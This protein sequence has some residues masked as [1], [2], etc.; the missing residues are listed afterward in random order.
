MGVELDA[1]TR[2]GGSPGKK[3]GDRRKRGWKGVFFRK[4]ILTNSLLQISWEEYVKDSYPDQD[5]SKL[6]GDDKKLLFEDEKY[7]KGWKIQTK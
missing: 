4:I 5:I 6:D 7:F 2:L 1:V 3:E